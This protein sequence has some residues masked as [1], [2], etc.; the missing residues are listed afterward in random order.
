MSSYF[1]KQYDNTCHD[2]EPRYLIQYHLN[3]NIFLNITILNRDKIIIYIAIHNHNIYSNVT[4]LKPQYLVKIT[5]LKFF[6]LQH[7]QTAISPQKKISSCFN[8]IFI[9]ILCNNYPIY[10]KS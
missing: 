7:L 1:S 2:F 8:L 6:K 4:I 9:C 3:H 10:R 5:V